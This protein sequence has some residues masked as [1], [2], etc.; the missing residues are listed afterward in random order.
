MVPVEQQQGVPYPAQTSAP[1]AHQTSSLH[2]RSSLFIHVDL[3]TGSPAAY[4]Q[5]RLSKNTSRPILPLTMWGSMPSK[6]QGLGRD[7]HGRLSETSK[8]RPA[9]KSAVQVADERHRESAPPLSWMTEP[10]NKSRS[11]PVLE[12]TTQNTLVL[13]HFALKLRGQVQ[14]RARAEHAM[15]RR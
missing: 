13:Q 11:P 12:C 6:V 3:N 1:E 2:S 7:E 9:D 14:M 8:K 15:K 5:G 10:C 4:I